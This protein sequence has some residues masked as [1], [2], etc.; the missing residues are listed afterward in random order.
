MLAKGTVEPA[1]PHKSPFI[2]LLPTTPLPENVARGPRRWEDNGGEASRH[3]CFSPQACLPPAPAR[4][5]P[6]RRCHHHCRWQRRCPVR[7][8]LHGGAGFN[9]V[10]YG[11][12]QWALSWISHD[13]GRISCPLRRV[14][15]QIQWA[16]SWICRLGCT[17]KPGQIL[18]M[19]KIVNSMT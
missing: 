10:C 4:L 3:S 1:P 16:V 12:I 9:P 18:Q 2:S 6:C 15:G 19:V 11:Q 5:V 13:H 7:L 14:S 8:W 17:G